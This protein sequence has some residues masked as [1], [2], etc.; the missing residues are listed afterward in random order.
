MALWSS[1]ELKKITSGDVT[2]KFE[3]GGV[4]ID[5][6]TIKPNDLFIAVKGSTDGHKYIKDAFSKGA[7][8]VLVEKKPKDLSENIP[9]LVVKNSAHALRQIGVAARKRCKAKV[10]AITGSVGKTSTKEM[11]KLALEGQGIIHAAEKSYNNHWGVPLT[12][13]N[14]PEMTKFAIFEI[15][16]SN[17]G[18]ILPLAQMI[19]PDVAI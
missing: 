6:R 5:T 11:I 4:S 13:A 9:I 10:I 14:M 17:P 18:E 12:L 2:G 16:T 8:A 19:R 15:G 3:V 1:E 7:S